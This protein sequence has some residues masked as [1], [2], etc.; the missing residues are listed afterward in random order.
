[1]QSEVKKQT[2]DP[3]DMKDVEED[4]DLIDITMEEGG[5][6]NGYD[7]HKWPSEDPSV[8]TFKGKKKGF[9]K[10]VDGIKRIM[11]KGTEKVMEN[12]QFKVVD[13]SKIPHGNEYEIQVV[14]DKEKGLAKIKIYGPN[15]KKGSSIVVNKAKNQD[16]K[17]VSVIGIEIIK[18]L[19][20]KFLC[21]DGWKNIFKKNQICKVCNKGF[22]NQGNLNIHM[23][24]FH[25][26]SVWLACDI[27][28]FICQKA[29]ELKVHKEDEHVMETDVDIGMGEIKGGNKRIRNNSQ[30]VAP[31][32][33]KVEVENEEVIK[34]IIVVGMDDKQNVTPIKHK[35]KLLED[36]IV[37]VNNTKEEQISIIQQKLDNTEAENIELKKVITKLKKEN[38]LKVKEYN[39]IKEENSKIKVKLGQIQWDKDKLEA[40]FKAREKLQKIKKNTKIFNDIIE[41]Q[42]ENGEIKDVNIDIYRMEECNEG[43][44]S[45][46]NTGS[47]SLKTLVENKIKGGK[48]TSPQDQS[49]FRK[50]CD[51]VRTLFKCPQ[52][53]FISQNEQRFNEHIV[54]AHVGQPTCPFCYIATRDYPSL[55]RHC[56]NK[57]K[58]GG[59]KPDNPKT[60]QNIIR[61]PK[62]CRFFKNGE[63]TCN[64]KSGKCS[65]DHS[66]IPFNQREL[67]R[68]KHQC[69][70]KPYCIFYHPEDKEN[71]KNEPSKTCKFSSQGVDCNRNNCMYVH[72]TNS[73]LGFHWEQLREPP[74]KSNWTDSSQTMMTS[75]WIERV[76]VIVM[77]KRRMQMEEEKE[78]TLSLTRSIKDLG[79]N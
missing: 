17:F 52:C 37:Q 59:D 77:N 21:G 24:K 68:H 10:A 43:E 44:E 16:L 2:G 58:E 48:R 23:A 31:P 18:Q 53:D 69:T 76:P 38:T 51:N 4:E 67:C 22:C 61:K 11:K 13:S 7:E 8:I 5:E 56:E 35:L 41:K 63:G 20:D 30:N 40:E 74:P 1:M 45:N 26:V 32:S 14:K 28:N 75:T 36:R 47:D 72:P 42:I 70:Y 12:I 46:E 33:K 6:E 19:L 64:P 27:C 29:D 79:L 34:D 73:G 9:V 15:N 78:E 55:R 66:F 62:P 71:L 50:G 57:H 39:Q 54:E 3:K 25:T 60:T 49:E 65:F